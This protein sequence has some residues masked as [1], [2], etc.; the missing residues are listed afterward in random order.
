MGCADTWSTGENVAPTDPGAPHRTTVQIR[1]RFQF[2]SALKRM[3]TVC[4]L[5]N[6]KAFAAVKGAP[7]T[8]KNMLAE[9][10]DSYDRTYKHYTRMGSRVLALGYREMNTMSGD[11]VR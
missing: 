10:P 9:V 3:S 4:N 5:P 11:K 6:G 2:S 8:V 1:R 7:E